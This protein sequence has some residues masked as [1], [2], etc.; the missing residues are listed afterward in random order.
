MFRVVRTLSHSPDTILIQHQMIGK[1]DEMKTTNA[2]QI[3]NKLHSYAI[4]S[5]IASVIFL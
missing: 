5:A 3:K 4:K 1:K 2:L